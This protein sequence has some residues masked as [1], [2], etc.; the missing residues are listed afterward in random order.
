VNLAKI[1]VVVFKTVCLISCAL[2]I[3]LTI[4]LILD[5]LIVKAGISIVAAV[6]IATQFERPPVFWRWLQVILL[7]AFIAWLFNGAIH[8]VF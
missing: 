5:L 3:A 1:N 8:I 7:L 6:I 2:L 4:Y